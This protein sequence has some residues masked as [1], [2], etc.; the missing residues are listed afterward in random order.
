MRIR[1]IRELHGPDGRGLRHTTIL[2][3]A[4]A[5]PALSPGIPL[6]MPPAIADTG[7]RV[8]LRRRRVVCAP[9]QHHSGRRSVGAESP[10]QMR[11]QTATLLQH[12]TRRPAP[13]FQVHDHSGELIEG[14]R[15]DY[16]RSGV[17][18]KESTWAPRFGLSAVPARRGRPRPA[19]STPSA[20]ST[21][22]PSRART[23]HRL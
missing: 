5:S 16:K 12:A 17:G 13:F 4:A 15:T 8:Q 3:P 9:K 18:R 10:S 23:L 2:I 20:R 14:T 22:A 21:R 11:S 7:R 19:G 6:A 1:S